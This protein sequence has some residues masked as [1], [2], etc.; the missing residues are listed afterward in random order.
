MS[1]IWAAGEVRRAGLGARCWE[2]DWVGK[3]HGRGPKKALGLG[4]G[5]YQKGENSEQAEP[6]HFCLQGNPGWVCAHGAGLS[7]RYTKHF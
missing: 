2:E 7:D 1:V 6:I 3:D 5:R 4:L